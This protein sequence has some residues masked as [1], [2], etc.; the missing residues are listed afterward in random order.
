MSQISIHRLSGRRRFME[1]NYELR[2]NNYYERRT[3]TRWGA[4]LEAKR[5]RRKID[6]GKRTVEVWR[7][8]Q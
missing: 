1:A 3:I 6:R 7:E 8:E 4:L 2:L 5:L